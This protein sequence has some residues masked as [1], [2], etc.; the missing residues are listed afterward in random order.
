MR[1]EIWL[2]R[3]ERNILKSKKWQRFTE[4]FDI[5]RKPKEVKPLPVRFVFYLPGDNRDTHTF[6][7]LMD[8]EILISVF[9]YQATPQR[10]VRA[11]LTHE[12]VHHYLRMNGV[13]YMDQSRL[14]H[15][16]LR[17]LGIDLDIKLTV[18]WRHRGSKDN[19]WKYR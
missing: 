18:K 2:E 1:E 15:K 5:G 16:A 13:A 11:F 7:Q 4:E 9:F 8:D 6:M 10:I 3:M 17:Y 14:F 19:R 12:L